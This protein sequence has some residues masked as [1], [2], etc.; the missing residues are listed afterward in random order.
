MCRGFL[1][2]LTNEIKL[3]GHISCNTRMLGA[4]KDGDLILDLFEE[5][6]GARVYHMYIYPGGVRR[7]LPEGFLERVSSLLVYMKKRLKDYDDI[8]INNASFKKRAIGV[9]VIS[10]E[11]AIVNGYVG[12]VLRA[13]GIKADVRK[14]APYLVYD[15]LEFEVPTQ[16]AGDVYARALVRRDE[17]D[18]SI[19]I[20][21]QVVEKMPDGEV[22]IKMPTHT[23]GSL[24]KTGIV[25]EDV[26]IIF[27]SFF[28]ID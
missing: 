5:L 17:M 23:N 10:K 22:M 7:D 16:T 27:E 4:M 8:F 25:N 12:Q 20:L 6:T 13:C 3:Y 2:R 14:D 19:H 1:Y 26:I 24:L 15:E 9:G 28:H 11:E 21:E 18:Q